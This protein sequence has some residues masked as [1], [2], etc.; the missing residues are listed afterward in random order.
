MAARREQADTG[1]VA[2][3]A[4]RLEGLPAAAFWQRSGN[5]G[6][7]PGSHFLG[8]LDDQPLELRVNHLRALRL[9]PHTNSPNVIGGW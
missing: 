8:T 6:A 7:T 2:V 5:P 3:N 4:D 9:E 1:L